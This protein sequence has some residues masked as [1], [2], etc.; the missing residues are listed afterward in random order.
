MAEDSFILVST[1]DD[2]SKKVAQILTND[3]CRK[4]LE[5]L[6]EREDSTESEIAK[7]L[8]LPISTVHYNLKQLSETGFLSDDHY[9]YSEKGKEVT[10]YRLA[11][12]FIIIAPKTTFGWKQKLRSILPVGLI[13]GGMALILAF[14]QRFMGKTAEIVQL[15]AAPMLKRTVAPA[16]DEA[17]G[18]AFNAAESSLMAET[19]STPYQHYQLFSDIA[20]WFFIGAVITLALVVIFDWAK[21]RKR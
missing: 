10:H 2:K 4:I 7:E 8:D 9:H 12:K 19:A 18:G 1:K 6:G 21:N 3:S 5:F 16:A 20:L 11:N 15:E 14:T 17:V 13:A